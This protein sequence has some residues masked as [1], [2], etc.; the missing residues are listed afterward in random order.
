MRPSWGIRFSAMS[1]PARILYARD[2]ARQQG[3]RECAHGLVEHV[4]RAEPHADL[5]FERLDVDV[6]GALLDGLL[7]QGV[8]EADDRRVVIGF[9]EILRLGRD[10]ARD[11][12]EVLGGAF[13]DVVDRTAAAVVGL[14]D[15]RHHDTAGREF[16]IDLGAVEEQAEVIDAGSVEGV[17]EDHPDVVLFAVAERKDTVVLGERDRQSTDEV[18]VDVA[19]GDVLMHR[20]VELGA[21]GRQHFVLG[22]EAELGHRVDQATAVFDAMFDRALELREVE[23]RR[24]QQDLAQTQRTGGARRRSHGS[25]RSTVT[26]GDKS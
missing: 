1:R 3:L 4:V 25:S 19:D 5:A 9:E 10:L 22:E 7:Q 6:A 13:D 2:D 24:A 15:R 17:E 26:T 12:G 16:G 8:D 18:E 21:E 23:P 11:R 14:V 20:K